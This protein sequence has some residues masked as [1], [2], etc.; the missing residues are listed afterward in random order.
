MQNFKLYQ[1]MSN[2]YFLLYHLKI[3]SFTAFKNHIEMAK[4]RPNIEEQEPRKYI[5]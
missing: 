2:N 4:F 5:N 1:Y 3:N